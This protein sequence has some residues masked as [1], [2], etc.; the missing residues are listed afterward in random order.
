MSILLL[1]QVVSPGGTFWVPTSINFA[2]VCWSTSIAI[3]I[4]L[5]IGIVGFLLYMR[6][7]VRRVM[8]SHHH[9]SYVSVSAMLVESALLYTVFALVFLIPLARNN[10]VNLIFFQA[11]GQVQVST[12][13]CM[14]RLQ[15]LDAERRMSL[16]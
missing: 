5:T 14:G 3:N 13:L 2:L 15:M 4:M 12:T 8:G 1:H 11:L 16:S 7:R 6:F 10:S 9:S